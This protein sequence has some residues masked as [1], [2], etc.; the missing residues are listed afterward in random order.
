ME[1]DPNLAE[2]DIRLHHWTAALHYCGADVY[3][4]A[5]RC[6]ELYAGRPPQ[7]ISSLEG[8]L[9][10]RRGGCQSWTGRHGISR[11]SIWLPEDPPGRQMTSPGTSL[12]L[13]MQNVEAIDLTHVRER[14]GQVGFDHPAVHVQQ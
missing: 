6:R 7:A 13:G 11:A 12:S 14:I 3:A 8:A 9:G 2:P 1:I 5:L 4:H 10:S